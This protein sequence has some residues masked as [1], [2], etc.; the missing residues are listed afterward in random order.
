MEGASVCSKYHWQC[1]QY[2]QNFHHHSSSTGHPL[3]P[4]CFN[5]IHWETQGSSRNIKK[6]MFIRV[7]DPSLNR[8]LGKYQ[9]P[10]IWDNILKDA[11]MP[12]VK[13]SNLSP[14]PYWYNPFPRLPNLPLTPHHQPQG[15]G[16][17]TFSHK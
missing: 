17:C 5:I 13:Q 9:L 7:N 2:F 12:Q 11:S 10:H 14:Y 4:E 6:A 8:N 1:C 15:G 3:S 16:T